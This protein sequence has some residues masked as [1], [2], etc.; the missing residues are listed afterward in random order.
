MA[1]QEQ[2]LLCHFCLTKRES[3]SSKLMLAKINVFTLKEILANLCVF[4][5]GCK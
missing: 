5:K 4:P 2:P 3:L 1:L